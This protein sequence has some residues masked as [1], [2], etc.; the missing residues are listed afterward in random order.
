MVDI[1]PIFQP[2]STSRWVNAP[3]AANR[4]LS[5]IKVPL[6]LEQVASNLFYG[7]RPFYV[8]LQTPEIYC[9]RWQ[10]F[11]HIANNKKVNPRWDLDSVRAR[12]FKPRFPLKGYYIYF[13]LFFFILLL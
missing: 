5:V 1:G 11:Q 12:N 2:L 4:Q 3:S 9:L 10:T 7:F 6:Q 8:F 13:I